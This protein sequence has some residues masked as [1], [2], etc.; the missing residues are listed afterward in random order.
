MAR[1]RTPTAV[2]ELKGAFKKDPQRR[3]TREGEPEAN[4]PIGTPPPNFD[5]ELIAIWHELVGMVPAK[6]LAT[7]DRWTVELACRMMQLLRKGAFRAAELN[8]LLTCLSRMGLTPADRSRI[9]VPQQK[10]EI[11]ELAALAA[12]GKAS[13]VN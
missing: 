8:I 13:H 5:E 12:E 7:S 4:G 2:L 9:A 3:Q 10:E 6:V 11:D 1:P